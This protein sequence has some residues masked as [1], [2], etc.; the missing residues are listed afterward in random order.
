MNS[1]FLHWENLRRHSVWTHLYWYTIVDA[2]FIHFTNYSSSQYLPRDKSALIEYFPLN[3]AAFG[4]SF[5]SQLCS[6]LKTFPAK[7]KFER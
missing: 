7:V 3:N 5:F 6:L 1:V 2:L 4:A